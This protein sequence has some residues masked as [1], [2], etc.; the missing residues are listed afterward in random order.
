MLTI[1]RMATIG[2]T[3]TRVFVHGFLPGPPLPA[4]AGQPTYVP[5]PVAIVEYEDGNLG[6]IA[7]SG[8]VMA[9]THPEFDKLR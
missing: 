6:F 4:V 3:T 9:E 5:E 2:N 1:N 8:L 7:M